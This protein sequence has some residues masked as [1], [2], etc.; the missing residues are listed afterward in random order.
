VCWASTAQ[1]ETLLLV[2]IVALPEALEQ[3]EAK[4]APKRLLLSPRRAAVARA[5]GGR[6]AARLARLESAGP[7]TR[8]LV[9]TLVVLFVLVAVAVAF[10]LALGF[11][12]LAI[13]PAVIAVAVAIWF[14]AALARGHTPRSATRRAERPELLGPGGLDD[15][16]G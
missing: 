1:R 4:L 11:G 7:G 16:G 9:I 6:E 13:A 10:A 5:R 3:V 14:L 15:P 12:P 8:R 2:E